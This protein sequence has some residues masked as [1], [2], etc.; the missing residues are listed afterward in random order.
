MRFSIVAAASVL[1]VV[2]CA[3]PDQPAQD[4]GVARNNYDPRIENRDANPYNVAYPSADLGT[5]PATWAGKVRKTPGQRIRNFKFLGHIDADTAELKTVA[6]ADYFDPE[7]K[8]PAG[9]IKLIH[10]QAA[11]VWCSACKSEAASLRPIAA[12]LREQGV[13]WLTTVCEGASPG[14]DSTLKDAKGNSDLT[15]WITQTKSQNT[16]VLD[17]GNYNLG[18]F[19]SAAAIPWNAWIDARTMEIIDHHIG[20][21]QDLKGDIAAALAKFDANEPRK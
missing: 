6:L 1:A 16:T 11:G 5:A 10:I 14:V 3:S 12:T 21:P 17:P 2:A 9:A 8:N 13:I 4:K 20:A 15:T 19:F 7:Q 18:V